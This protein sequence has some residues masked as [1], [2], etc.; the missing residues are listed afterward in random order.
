MDYYKEKQ[1]YCSEKINPDDR[2]VEKIRNG[3]KRIKK[4]S[5]I[6]FH[7]DFVL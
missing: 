7:H 2:M 1:F 3:R 4:Q 5:F 6:G